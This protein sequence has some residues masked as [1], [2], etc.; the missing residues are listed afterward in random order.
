MGSA[1][2][3][4]C[5]GKEHSAWTGSQHALAMQEANPQSVLGRFDGTR[6]VHRGTTTTFFK[7]DDR[8]FVRTDGPDGKLADFEIAYTFGV[9]P[10][11]QYLVEL[12]GGRLQALGVAWDAR[13]RDRGG[14]RWFHLYP[15]RTLRAGDPLHWTGID[16]NWN[17]QCADCHSTNVR[18]GF[19]ATTGRFA[20]SWS[21]VSVG[22]EACHGPASNH[23][24]WANREGE[25]QGGAGAGKGLTAVL[26]E[27]RDAYWVID[28]ASGN[29]KR[30][31]PRDSS[32]EL[33]VCARCHSRRAQFSDA[34]AA[35]A[36]FHDAFRPALLEPDLYFPDGQ[37]REEVYSHAPFLTSRMQ[38]KGVTCSDC[39]D[40]HSQRPRAPGNQVCAQ[41]H[42]PAKYDAQSHHHHADGP[43]ARCAACHMPTR[44][45][46]VVDPRHDHS[47][48]IPRPDRSLSLGVPNACT[49]CHAQRTAQWAARALERW[50]PHPKPGFQSFAEAFAAGEAGRA[51]ARGALLAV[52]EN[53]ETPALVRASAIARLASRLTPEAV[54]SIVRALNDPDADVRTAA[55]RA[56]G[57]TDA[58]TRA[59]FLPRML[60]DAS[61]LV[62][63]EAARALAGGAESQLDAPA[64]AA[65]ERALDELVAAIRFNADRPEA[66]S[67]LGALHAARGRLD[68]P[69]A[70]YR[71]ALKIDP[72]YIP[73]S[74]NLADLYRARGREDQAEATLREALGREPA[75]AAAWQALGL[76]LIRQRR[77]DEALAAL[78]RAAR[79]APG[80]ARMAYVY[81]VALHDTGKPAQALSILRAALARHPNDPDLLAAL[82]SYEGEA[83]RPRQA[84]EYARRLL[85]I[86]PTDQAVARLVR[87][88]EAAAR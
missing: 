73:A 27:R 5:H 37:Q 34:H 7:R 55:V 54:D 39:H 81:G 49:Q 18:K 43:G 61:R 72:A 88:L 75:S 68:E 9:Y 26:D 33:D 1:A 76:S 70:S 32:R 48:R 57:G 58:A 42:A 35:G 64:R 11:Q 63:M 44:T 24:A 45:Y 65:F 59:R 30:S 86:E 84:L 23:L 66:H 50:Y 41:C 51:G 4:A 8:F 38:A 31:K 6:Y 40:A 29:A 80:E 67:N 20:T 2:C 21:E 53:R 82:T 14:Q 16:Q 46:M 74:I 85:A 25:R 12:S 60:S 62:R 28:A 17:Y 69:E 47:I 19:D 13:P 36:A 79:A 22:C 52:L 3:A 87:D 78:G 83:G 71:Q 15:E 10:L 77:T 56:L